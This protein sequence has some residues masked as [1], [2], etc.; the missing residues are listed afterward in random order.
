MKLVTP[1]TE[2]KHKTHR[3]HKPGR[4]FFYCNPISLCVG[5]ISSPYKSFYWEMKLNI[6]K[7]DHQSRSPT[8]SKSNSS[9]IMLKNPVFYF[10]I[11]PHSICAYIITLLCETLLGI[12]RIDL[13]KFSP[14]FGHPYRFEWLWKSSPVTSVVGKRTILFLFRLIW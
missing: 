2:L 13:D 6:D 3:N 12:W 7:T 4:F 1:Q 11:H 14:E 5:I 10:D 8:I 9:R